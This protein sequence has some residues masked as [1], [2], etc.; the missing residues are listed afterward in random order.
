[1]KNFFQDFFNLGEFNYKW[2][3]GKETDLKS[4]WPFPFSGFLGT[5]GVPLYWPLLIGG[6]RDPLASKFSK[7]CK[8]GILSFNSPVWELLFVFDFLVSI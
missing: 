4:N 7:S 6:N 1:M 2:L 5:K 8:E 3:I